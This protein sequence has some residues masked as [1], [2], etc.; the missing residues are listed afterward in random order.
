[1]A[2]VTTSVC[3]TIAAGR[4]LSCRL[5]PTARALS[6]SPLLRTVADYGEVGPLHCRAAVARHGRIL[7]TTEHATK[8]PR[9]CH[10]CVPSQHHDTLS[11]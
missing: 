3:Y 7:G 4:A 6:S 11:R 10:Y 9:A 2:A 1:M 5:C 8:A